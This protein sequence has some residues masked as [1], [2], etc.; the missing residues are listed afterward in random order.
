MLHRLSLR[1]SPLVIGLAVMLSGCGA[2]S[3]LQDASTVLQVYELRAPVPSSPGRTLPLEVVIEEPTTGGALQTDR[4][5]IRPS[6]LQAQYLPG[7][8]WSDTAPVMV[9]TLMLRSLETSERLRYVGR[10]PLGISGDYAVLTELVDFQAELGPDGDAGQVVVRMISRV[11]R[12]D[13]TRIMGS[14][15]FAVTVPVASSAAETVIAGFDVA[16]GQ[17][18]AEHAD[19]VLS[20][21][22]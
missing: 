17:L 6:P 8:R 12:E 3:A 10:T 15:T 9:Q 21:V 18:F 19:W 11:V 14:R 1:R 20:V 13:D 22:R 5:M 4:I 2:L 16:A 7:V